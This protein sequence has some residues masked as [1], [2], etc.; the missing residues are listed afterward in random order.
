MANAKKMNEAKQKWE[1]ASALEDKGKISQAI[2]IY[3]I[4]AKLGNTAAMSNLGNL[5]DD[6]LK[7]RRPKEA[8]YW[9]KRAVRRGHELAAWNLAMH[10][11]NLGKRRWYVHWLKV[12]ARMGDKEATAELR[13]FVRPVHG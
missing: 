11:R 3:K 13:K 10:Y 12:A 9:Y 4:S 6:K 8:V 1:L 2:R 5:L 7:V